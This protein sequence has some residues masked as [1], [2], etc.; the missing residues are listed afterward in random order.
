MT[1]DKRLPHPS[2]TKVVHVRATL[3]QY[4]AWIRA[5]R[6]ARRTLSSWVQVALDDAADEGGGK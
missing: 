5:A 2:R 4:E 3:E 1:R 6:L